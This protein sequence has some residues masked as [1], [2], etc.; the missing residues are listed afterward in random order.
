MFLNSYGLILE[1]F[2]NYIWGIVMGINIM[3]I[4]VG[5]VVGFVLGGFLL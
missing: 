2:D 5:F 3:F 4:F 1:L